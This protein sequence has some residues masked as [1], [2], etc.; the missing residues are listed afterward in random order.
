MMMNHL[1]GIRWDRHCRMPGMFSHG[2][3]IPESRTVGI[4][5]PIPDR[6]RADFWVDATTEMRSPRESDVN[7]NRTATPERSIRLPRR[8]TPI[9]YLDRMRM[10]MKLTVETRR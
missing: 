6:S 2:K 8:G 5:S 3:I 9:M 10:V 7:T 1:A 4:I